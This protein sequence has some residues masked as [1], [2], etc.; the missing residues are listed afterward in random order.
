MIGGDGMEKIIVYYK[1]RENKSA[2]EYEDYFRN[3]KYSV[4]MNFPSVKEF[5]LYRADEMLT[6]KKEFDFLGELTVTSIEEYKKDRDSEAFKEFI[7]K[8][9]S[10]ALPESMK[11]VSLKEIKA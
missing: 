4:V 7:E 3:E 9:V 10:Y 1:L 8:W 11:V 6:G 2:E 5:K